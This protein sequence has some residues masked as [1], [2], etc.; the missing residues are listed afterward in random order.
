MGLTGGRSLIESRGRSGVE[1]RF[2]RDIRFGFRL[3][4]EGVFVL[5]EGVFA[6]W[7]GVLVLSEGVLAVWEGAFVLR[8][9]MFVVRAWPPCRCA[10]ETGSAGISETMLSRF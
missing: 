2:S 8:V 7:E 6:V 10:L 4:S 5:S 1:A 3:G 9:G